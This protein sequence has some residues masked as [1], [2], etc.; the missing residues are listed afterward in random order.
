M[1]TA[2]VCRCCRL[3]E[4]APATAFKRIAALECWCRLRASP[5]CSN[6][7]LASVQSM[8]RRIMKNASKGKNEI[9][10]A[11]EVGNTH[12]YIYMRHTPVGSNDSIA[13]TCHDHYLL[14]TASAG[15]HKC[16]HMNESLQWQ[17]LH[18][19]HC[20]CIVSLAKL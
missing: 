8:S 9:S 1:L 13:Q 15:V 10:V 16:A 2:G 17:L 12:M 14:F 18:L 7:I 4:N 3:V 6:E 19:R 5:F 20:F 11:G